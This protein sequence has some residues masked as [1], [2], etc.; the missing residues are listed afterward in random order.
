MTDQQHSRKLEDCLEASRNRL[1]EGGFNL[2]GVAHTDEFDAC[3]CREG[4]LSKLRQGAASVVVVGSG[5]RYFWDHWTRLGRNGESPR[6]GYDPIDDYSQE[7]IGQ[8]LRQ[9][10]DAG[11]DACAI[12]PFGKDPVNF[13]QLGEAAGLGVVS[14]AMPLLLHPEFGPWISLRGALVFSEKIEASPALEEFGPCADCARPC[15]TACPVDAIAETGDKEWARCA[16]HRHEG[17][18]EGSCDVRRACPVG[19][20]HAYGKEEEFFRHRYTLQPLRKAYGLGL[21]R[22]VPSFLRRQA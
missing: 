10:Q 18:C 9:F 12:Y 3:Q 7:Q 4:R 8:E 22:F 17:G 1:A 6:E 5:G 14:P 13:L 2:F 21:W 15:Q 19:S 11:F 20:E 16:S